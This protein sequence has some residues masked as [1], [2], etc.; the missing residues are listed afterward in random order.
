[1]SKTETAA[2]VKD[3]SKLTFESVFTRRKI[4]AAYWLVVLLA[5]P[6]WWKYTSI[7]RLSLPEARVQ[8]VA[9]HPA[10]VV[11]ADVSK[12]LGEDLKD[13]DSVSI[14]FVSK[15][16][17]DTYQV[18]L[19]NNVDH[20]SLIG[21]QL[22]IGMLPEDD[23]ESIQM[24]RLRLA[25]ILR[26]MLVPPPPRAT[27]STQRVVKY[28][29][30]YRLAFTLLNE[31]SATG[32]AAIS[33][34]LQQSMGQ[35]LGPS[36]DR[37]KV[38]HNFT[39]ESQIQFHAPLAFA[40]KTVEHE[41]KTV[42][43]LTHEDLTVFVNSAEWTLSSS[44]S[45]DPVLH[46]VLFVPSANHTPLHILDNEGKP[47]DSNAFILP[48]WGGIVIV[49][50]PLP[51]LSSA[52]LKRPFETFRAQLLA[53][54]GVPELPPADIKSD[55]PESFS[56]WQLDALIRQRTGEN[57][58]DSQETLESIVKLVNQ[59]QNMPV[60]KDVKGDVQ[61]ALDALER[62]FE[63]GSSSA[64]RALQYSAEALKLSSRAFFNPNN[65]GLL[66]FPAEHKYAVYTPLFASV[67]APLVAAVI[68]ELLAW[69]RARREQVAAGE[70]TAE[71]P[72]SD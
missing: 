45:N 13:V 12:L 33:W 55:H 72:K 23:D 43:G 35:Y 46:F 31:D 17:P 34:D 67:A 39:V 41:G 6:L 32:K 49:N 66:Y 18:R 38:L 21:R 26:H 25:S 15:S 27:S 68:R 64:A 30:R 22:S 16:T 3:P 52:A 37:F 61:S 63:V 7:D 59:I 42:H 36:L 10:E 9:T 14:D 19:H 40:P 28:S 69:R 11:A 62:A 51:H 5:V 65:L 54:L 53:L 60:G 8:S 48:Q 20:T 57:V 24:S 44:V 58:K 1:M 70:K 47:S 4:L 56:D 2:G 29:P 50:R 71:K